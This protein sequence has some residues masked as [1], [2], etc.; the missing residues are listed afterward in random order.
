MSIGNNVVDRL[1][2]RLT[3][4]QLVLQ[5]MKLTLSIVELA[6]QTLVSFSETFNCH[7]KICWIGRIRRVGLV[8]IVGTIHYDRKINRFYLCWARFL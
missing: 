5:S 4:L 1:L 7:R 6:Q 2:Q 3:S 8:G